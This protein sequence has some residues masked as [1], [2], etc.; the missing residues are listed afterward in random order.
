[1]S[2]H[3]STSFTWHQA[4]YLWFFGDIMFWLNRHLFREAIG[5]EVFTSIA[6]GQTDWQWRWLGRDL[7]VLPNAKKTVW[8][9]YP[10]LG[11]QYQ[12]CR[13]PGIWSSSYSDDCRI[14]E[15]LQT[16]KTSQNW[17]HW[18]RKKKLY[19]IC[20]FMAGD[21]SFLIYMHLLCRAISSI[22]Q[23][24]DNHPWTVGTWHGWFSA[25]GNGFTPPFRVVGA[26]HIGGHRVF[27]IACHLG[28]ET[29]C[30]SFHPVE[31]EWFESLG[32]PRLDVH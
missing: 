18:A 22:F 24:F 19:P 2:F 3:L 23:H 1:M 9:S 14:F 5:M 21:L 13:N 8:A 6:W 12:T 26:Q 15:K 4:I 16:R 31:Q 28:R 7:F 30:A 10:P 11:K 27:P 29:R 20:P 17:V 25:C 32:L